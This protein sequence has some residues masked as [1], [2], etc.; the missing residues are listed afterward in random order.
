MERIE[1][2]Q[3]P[4][5]KV[6]IVPHTM[7]EDQMGI[8]WTSEAVAPLMTVKIVGTNKWRSPAKKAI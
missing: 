5:T 6:K 1:A 4:V 3:N 8:T 2:L 7:Y